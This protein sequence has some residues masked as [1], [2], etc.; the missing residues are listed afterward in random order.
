MGDADGADEDAKF[1]LEKTT[2]NEDILMLKA[3]IEHKR[4][5]SDEAISY[6][7]KVV[8]V[9]PF[10]LDAF[11]ER[12]AVKMEK[13]DKNGAAEDMQQVLELDPKQT[14]D[15]SG[16]YSAEGVEE[17]TRQA[18]KNINPFGI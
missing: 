13:G 12:G 9:N 4:G 16:E 17:K 5:N 7:N 1:L 10:L 3:R 11:K 14:A 8:D 2:D 6:Y 15:V 18:Y